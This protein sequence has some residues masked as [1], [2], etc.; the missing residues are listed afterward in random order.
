MKSE[1]GIQDDAY[2]SVDR[3]EPVGFLE[4]VY[5]YARQ[6]ALFVVFFFPL[7]SWCV[8]NGVKPSRD[9]F[10]IGG[11]FRAEN[12]SPDGVL[13]WA[14]VA[15]NAVVTVGL[16]SLLDVYLRNQTQIAT[17]YLGLVDNTGFS[18]YSASDTMSSH[19]GWSESVAYSNSTRVA[20]SP[21]AASA[22]S[23]SNSSTSDFTINASATIKGVFLTSG[24][25]KSGTTGTL[26]ATAN[27]SGG[28]QTVNSGDTLK[29]TYTCSATSS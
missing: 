20:W 10:K 6:A 5:Y 18:A 19:A 2:A 23:I 17:W 22:G 4:T 3:G 11:I 14:D 7:L 15:K 29:V 12:Y 21:S 16:N 8:K 28:N 1:F 25:A 13:L 9:G 26:F 24:S 27:F